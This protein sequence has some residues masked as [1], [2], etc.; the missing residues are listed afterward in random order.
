[1]HHSRDLG[2]EQ[3]VVP[4]GQKSASAAGTRLEPLEEAQ[5]E[6]TVGYVAAWGPLLSSPLL[7]DTATE[8]VDAR[9]VKFLLQV[10]LEKKKEDEEKECLEAWQLAEA[11]ERRAKSMLEQMDK[12]SRKRK[13]GKKKELPRGGYSCGR[14]RRRHRRWH[15]RALH[16]VFPSFA[17]RLM[18]PGLLVVWMRR[19]VMLW[20]RSSLS[21]A[22][23]YAGLVLH[24]GQYAPKGQL[25]NGPGFLLVTMLLALCSFLLSFT[26]PRCSASWP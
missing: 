9:T 19:T 17:G 25:R 20:P 23:A 12:V 21:P 24:H 2:S 5:G 16:A 26:G 4:R 7:A 15:V 22:A 8:A 13:K 14:A 10:A 1:M 18:M 6:V 3:H 11:L